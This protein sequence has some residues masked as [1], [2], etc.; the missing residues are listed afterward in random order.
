VLHELSNKT[1][2]IAT[3]QLH[4]LPDVDYVVCMKH[5]RIAEQGTFRE[6]MSNKGD[7][8]KLMKQYGGH[9]HHD[10]DHRP[11]RRVLKRNKSSTG[12]VVVTATAGS[13]VTATTTE[14]DDVLTILQE[15]EET[16]SVEDDE[17]TKEIPKGQMTDEE[18]ASGAVSM[19]VYREYFRLG[20]DWNWVFIVFLLS[21]QQA[22]GVA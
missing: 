3:H 4:V 7:F 12:K 8:F 14:S 21:A 22:A 17:S 2:V 16:V 19:K 11:H 13:I 15:L 6:L 20:G 18:R 9:H 5:G 10:D 1:R